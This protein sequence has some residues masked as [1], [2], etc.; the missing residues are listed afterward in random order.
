VQEG[1]EIHLLPVNRQK[2]TIE[3]R[4]KYNV[5]SNI[6]KRTLVPVNQGCELQSS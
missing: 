2:L 5:E 4:T 6:I 1:Y 3:F